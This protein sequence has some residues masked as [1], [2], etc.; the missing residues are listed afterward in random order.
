[1]LAPFDQMAYPFRHDGVP[2]PVAPLPAQSILP[3]LPSRSRSRKWE[4]RLL[5]HEAKRS[6]ARGT[7]RSMVERPAAGAM[8]G[9]GPLRLARTCRP[10]DPPPPLRR[11][12]AVIGAME[13][14]CRPAEFTTVRRGR[15]FSVLIPCSNRWP[16][17]R[18]FAPTPCC[19][20]GKAS[21]GASPARAIAERIAVTSETVEPTKN[22]G[23]ASIYPVFPVASQR[24]QSSPSF[25]RARVS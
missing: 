9:V 2:R 23:G 1:M 24:A 12:G 21:R 3:I 8:F 15:C 20:W 7:L 25:S 22:G 4:R 11:G 18:R 19:R 14:G 13:H 17:R 10:C 16:P 6:G 5:P